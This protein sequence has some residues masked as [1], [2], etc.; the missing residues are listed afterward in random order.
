MSH[1]LSS[2]FGFIRRFWKNQNGV[3][4]AVFAIALVPIIGLMG[5]A[6]DI[7][8]A[9]Q[10]KEAL[11]ASTD[12]AVLAGAQDISNGTGDPVATAK[13]YSAGTG[14]KNPILNLTVTATVTAKCFKS[15]GAS[16]TGPSA[17]NGLIV[18]Q[19]TNVP[20]FFAKVFGFNSIPVTVISTAGAAGSKPTP[21][22]VMLVLDTTASMGNTKDPYCS[23]P[24]AY[25]IDCA[26]AGVQALLGILAPSVDQVGL[27]VFPGLQANTVSYDTDCKS[28][29][30]PTIVAYSASPTYQ[31]VAPSSDYR[32]SDTSSSLSSNS[33][34]VNAVGGGASCSS[35]I[36]A[37]GG[38]GTFFS[39][40]IWQAQTSLL[41]TDKQGMQNVIV[42]LSD[43]DADSSQVLTK[44]CPANS[45]AWCTGNEA[46]N[47]CH[48]GIKAAQAAAS[49]GTW[50]FSIAYNAATS[51]SCVTDNPSISACSTMQQIASNSGKFYSDSTGV[52]GACTSSTNTMTDLV[53]IFQTIGQALQQPRLLPNDTT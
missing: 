26:L 44:S 45:S 49:S 53:A 9:L 35:G 38:V 29:T 10:V 42:F 33:S 34:L 14:G 48:A 16:C 3:T 5:F 1:F 18:Q 37:V 28:N 30:K 15:T 25:R 27:M 19:Q 12:A 11:Q 24:G 50:V 43:G 47:Q 39:D 23:I 8:N 40:A 20:T 7:G 22:N 36:T 32:S 2:P 17:A 21:L 52:K 6:I 41:A 13:S 4:A 46:T 51:G 31:I